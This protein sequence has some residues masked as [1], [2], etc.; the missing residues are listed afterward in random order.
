[1]MKPKSL[2]FILFFSFLLF[3]IN[4]SAQWESLGDDLIPQNHRVWS[5]KMAPDYSIWAIST[6]DAFP[7]V[8]QVPKVHR[9]VD[10]GVTWINTEIQ[11]GVSTYGWDISPIDSMNA[12]IALDAAGLFQTTNGGQ[13]WNKVE[14]Y[15]N[16]CYAIHFFNDEEGW[17]LGYD[18]SNSPVMSLTSDGGGSWTHV[19]GQSWDQPAGTSLPSKDPAEFLPAFLYSVNSSYDYSDESIIIGTFKGTY[20]LSTDKGYNWSRHDT[21][22]V[23]LGLMATNVAMK[24]ENTFMVAGDKELAT[25]NNV[26]AV[27]FTTTDGGDNWVG[28]NSGVTAAATH[29]IPE[30]DGIFIMVGHNNFGWGSEGTA[31]T[32]DYGENWEIID[33]TSLISIDFIDKENGVG[34]CCNNVWP[35]A[36]GQIH[37]WNF[38]LTPTFELSNSNM[39]DLMPNPVSDI[40]TVEMNEQFGIGKLQFDV[41]SANGQIVKSLKHPNSNKI[42]IETSNLSNGFYILKIYGNGKMTA[43]KFIKN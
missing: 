12:F 21:P 5:I 8:N 22:L 37:K 17:V 38:D 30:S 35:T 32:Y 33:Y 18:S 28:G 19:G 39:I 27:N 24:D 31:V 15:S 42:E 36:N 34:A 13:S 43:K 10:D 26:A 9:S 6:F 7:P 23:G 41:V 25:F 20:W 40:L 4:L 2:P 14:A 29:Y 16:V 1:M 11:E 3:N